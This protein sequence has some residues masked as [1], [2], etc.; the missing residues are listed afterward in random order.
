MGDLDALTRTISDTLTQFNLEKL[1]AVQAVP[2]LKERYSLERV[3]STIV[4]KLKDSKMNHKKVNQADVS[5]L[6]SRTA[7]KKCVQSALKKLLR[8]KKLS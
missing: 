8:L 1:E 3:Y 2:S 7:F 6:N 5:F 4:E